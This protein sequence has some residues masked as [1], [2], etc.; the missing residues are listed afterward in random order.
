MERAL[1]RIGHLPDGAVPAGMAALQTHLTNVSPRKILEQGLHEYLEEFL[2]L[3]AS[4][5]DA[6]Q[7]DYFEAHMA[8]AATAGETA[9]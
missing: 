8:D 9:A 4:L 5:T 6:L 3:L 2:T 7:A 1:A